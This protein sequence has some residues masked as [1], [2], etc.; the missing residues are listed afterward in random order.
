MRVLLRYIV[1]TTLIF[2]SLS[3]YS[4]FYNGSQ[5][6]FGKNRV[7]YNKDRLWFF[8]R[9]EKF[10]TYFYQGGDNLAY[11]TYRYANEQIQIMEE[12]LDYVLNE[13]A[14]FLIFQSLNDLKESNIGLISDEQYNVGG[15]THLVDNKIFIYFNGNHTDL[16][17]Q[18]R[19][20]TANI[21]INQM[22]TGSNMGSAIKNSTLLSLP[23][24][25]KNGLIA[26]LA[27]PW[28]TETDNHVRDGM[29]SGRY[30][31]FNSLRGDDATYAG[32][33]IWKFIADKY[34]KRVIPNLIYMTKAS[35]NIESA[36]LYVLGTSYDN[37]VKEWRSFYAD[38]YKFNGQN[39]DSI[40]GDVVQK[41]V[42][43]KY[44]YYNPRISPDGNWIVYAKNRLGKLKIYLKN[45]ETGDRDKIFK[46]GHKLD[47][48]TDYTYPIVAWH[49]SSKLFTMIVERKGENYM[50][51]YD[52]ETK[53]LERQE[54]FSLQKILDVDYNHKGSKLVLSAV[55]EGQTDIFV[56][57]LASETFEQI[58]NDVYDDL[59]PRFINNSEDIVFSSNRTSD[60]LNDI[61]LNWRERA[62]QEKVEV[63]EAFNVFIY[64]YEEEKRVLWRLTDSEY[65]D[66]TQ[67]EEFK[68]GYVAYLSDKNGIK[69]RYIAK[70]DSAVSHVDTTVHYRYFSKTY[71]L[72]DYSRN[73]I[74][75]DISLKS[76]KL[77]EHIYHNGLD[78]FFI[79]DLNVQDSIDQSQIQNTVYR[80]RMLSKQKKKPV[81]DKAKESQDTLKTKVPEKRLVP[82]MRGDEVAEEESEDT[83]SVDIR[84]YM[85]EEEQKNKSGETDTTEEKGKPTKMNYYVEYTINKLVSQVDFSFM[86][87]SYQP[88]TGGGGPIFLNAG[89]NG[90]FMVGATDLM[91][92]YR[93]TG[94]VRLSPNLRNN[95]YMI[96]YENL[97]NRLD[98]QWVFH[99]KSYQNSGENAIQKVASH[100]LYYN[101]KYA[102]SQVFSARGTAS[103][104]Y[105]RATILATDYFTL[106][107]PNEHYTWAGLKT[108]LVFDN[109]RD[110]GINTKFGTRWKT[111]GEYYQLLDR[112]RRNINLFV[113]GMDFRNYLPI[114]RSLVW[115]NRFAASSSF[116]TSKL[117]YY[118]GGVNNWLTASFNRN[119]PI[120]YDQNYAYQTLATPMRGFQQNIRNGNTFALFNSELRFPFIRYFSK[121]PLKSEFLSSLQLIGFMDVGSAWTGLNPYSDENTMIERTYRDKPFTVKVQRTI[122]PMV[123]GAGAGIRAKI[124]GYFV[125]LDYAWGYL[126][127]KVQDPRLY[128]SFNLDF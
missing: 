119:V 14:H 48:K 6:D 5:V 13:K 71:P 18:I 36:F 39:R 84:N 21:I 77:V 66:E 112:D 125:R 102:F 104:R 89:F 69:N 38:R 19:M 3:A 45:L 8:Y 108:S 105:D 50:Y 44:E 123:G 111:F 29:L 2:L 101:A 22:L 81:S 124:F 82:M 72:S 52:M 85:F 20:G 73:I 62:K 91:E 83:T 88:F 53:E 34:G 100:N 56:F 96:S 117:I 23:D 31:D 107:V 76:G 113:V 114:H 10:N 16:E 95:E 67:P 41:R 47:Q 15:I 110:R 46:Q 54:L 70:F 122:E 103:L 55:K 109:T 30:D 116:G 78:K 37:L 28:D 75:Q 90:L 11:Y 65:S 98:H 92:D 87:E 126:E 49:P 99:R 120:D 7:Q 64:H 33:S 12:K 43:E 68:N 61:R 121:K 17:Y 93:I 63:S 59:H 79:R 115:A 97:K 27:N 25:Y 32:H 106:Q 57:N 40:K 42:K 94:G 9:F 118:M 35:R 74:N 1:I 4:Q 26:Y 60:T 86:N 51:Y 24:W 58:T 128:L 80:S 127:R